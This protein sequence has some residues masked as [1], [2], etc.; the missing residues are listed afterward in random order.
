MTTHPR[1]T[2]PHRLR[3]IERRAQAAFL[4]LVTPGIVALARGDMNTTA[5]ALLTAAAIVAW[6][7][8]PTR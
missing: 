7:A 4:I 2:T 5:A 8:A 1:R 3:H 6:V